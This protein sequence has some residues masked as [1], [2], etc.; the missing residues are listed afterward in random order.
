MFTARVAFI[1][2]Y[3]LLQSDAMTCDVVP[4]LR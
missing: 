4:E 3:W 1:S 2:T